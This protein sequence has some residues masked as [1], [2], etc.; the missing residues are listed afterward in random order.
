MDFLHIPTR[1]TWALQLE[2]DLDKILLDHTHWEKVSARWCLNLLLAYCDNE[3]LSMEM[4]KMINQKLSQFQEMR[5]LLKSQAILFA[6]QQPIGYDKRLK[7]L[8]VNKEPD[9]VVDRL[10]VS[11]LQEAR[12][13]ERFAFMANCLEDDTVAGHY[14]ELVKSDPENYSTFIDLATHY[15]AEAE[16]FSRLDELAVYESELIKTGGAKPRLHS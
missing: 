8:I 13:Y 10:L 6:R 14:Q 12:S 4:T 1:P 5:E 11:A 3:T 7:E 2:S 9:R 15:K 16:V